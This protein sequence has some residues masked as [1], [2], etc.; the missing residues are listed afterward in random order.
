[1]GL[2]ST[3]AHEVG[4]DVSGYELSDD[5]G[6]TRVQFERAM[7]EQLRLYVQVMR[8]C[9]GTRLTACVY[10]REGLPVTHGSPVSRALEPCC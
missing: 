6:F 3:C 2:A 5:G 1:M 9:V 7:R 10:A 8:V 4:I